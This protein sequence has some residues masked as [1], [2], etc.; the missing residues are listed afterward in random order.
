[1]SLPFHLALLGLCLFIPGAAIPSQ[2]SEC[3]QQ[4]Q[5]SDYDSNQ[6]L[7]R[8]EYAAAIE[9][10]SGGEINIGF[11]DL[12]FKIQEAFH[13]A[14]SY[15]DLE[16]FI[17]LRDEDS[18]GSICGTIQGA[19]DH[20]MHMQQLAD[21][22]Q[23]TQ[24]LQIYPTPSR[25]PQISIGLDFE[26]SRRLQTLQQCYIA[27]SISDS[28]RDNSVSSL[29]YVRFINQL[30][31]Q[32][33]S[34]SNY[35]N[36]PAPLQANFDEFKGT[37]G[38]IDVTGS[39]PGQ[40]PTGEQ[41]VALASICDT[42]IL[43]L[44]NLLA[45]PATPPPGPAPGPATTSAPVGGSGSTVDCDGTI[46]RSRCNIALSIADLSRDDLLTQVEYVRFINRL[47]QNAYIG[48][49]YLSLPGNLVVNF[50]KFALT[51]GQI[52]VTGSKSGST[53]TGDQNVFIDS[54]CCETDFAVQNPEAPTTQAPVTPTP[55]PIGDIPTAP[56]PA[57]ATLP[58]TF[59][60][61]L[62]RSA[63][64]S[65]D[66]DQNAK[67]D[68][69]EYVRYLNRLTRNDFLGLE[70]GELDS[71][72]QI[73]FNNLI[74]GDGQIV[75]FGTR[76]NQDADAQQEEFI[77]R[78]CLDTA[79]ALNGG[80][81]G[82]PA[83]ATQ[84]P[85]RAPQVPVPTQVPQTLAPTFNFISC[86]TA[87]A[88]S[89][90]NRDDMINEEEYVRFLNRL[91]KN[92]LIGLNFEDLESPLPEN[93]VS[94]AKVDGQINIVGSKPGQT[95]PDE[96][97]DFLEQLCV[98]TA[99]AL[100]RVGETLSPTRAPVTPAIP[101]TPTVPSPTMPNL[102]EGIAEVYNSFIVS[103][104]EGLAAKQLQSGANRDDLDNGYETFAMQSVEK[105]VE[106][107]R[108]LQKLENP[109]SLRR[110]R[111]VSTFVADSDEIYL[112]QDVE[113]PDA[114]AENLD[115]QVAFAKFQVNVDDDED[116][117]AI[118]EIYTDSTQ[119]FIAAGALQLALLERDDRTRLTIVKESFPVSSTFS[120]SQAPIG[121][122]TSA[123]VAKEE[124]GDGGGGGVV[125]IVVGIIVAIVVIGLLAYAY[126]KGWI[127]MPSGDSL[128]TGDKK[129]TKRKKTDDD[130]DDDDEF[131][132][133]ERDDDDGSEDKDKGNTFGLEAK[134]DNAFGDDDGDPFGAKEQATDEKKGFGFG[135]KK[136]KKENKG[137]DDN[138]AFGEPGKTDTFGENDEN[139]DFG[140][141]AFDEP[142]I[143]QDRQEALETGSAGGNETNMFETPESPGGGAGFGGDFFG[144]SEPGWGATEPAAGEGDN[145]F[146]AAGGFGEDDAKSQGSQSGSGSYTSSDDSTYESNAVGEGD[147]EGD[148][149]GSEGSESEDGTK[150]EGSTIVSES[151]R[152]MPA[153]LRRKS[154]N[155][156]AM[157]EA[158]NWDAIANAATEFEGGSPNNSKN[159]REGSVRNPESIA[160]GDEDEDDSYSGSGSQSGSDDGET[161]ATS[162]HTEAREKRAEY[163]AQVEALVR[164]VVPD[165]LGKVDAMM[166]QFEG[167]EAELVSTLQ[168]MQERSATQRARAAVHKSKTKPTRGDGTRPDGFSMQTGLSGGTEGSAAGTAAI[169]AASLPIPADGFEGAD[170][171]QDDSM[172]FGNDAFGDAMDAEGSY[173]DDGG[174]QG[175]RSYYSDED[176]SRSGS[177]SY[178]SDEEGGSQ[179]S[180]SYYS[181][182]EG[183]SQEGGSQGGGSQVGSQDG[184][185]SYYSDEEEGSPKGSSPNS[186]GSKGSRSFDGEA[187]GSY[188]DDGSEGDEGAE[189]DG[190]Q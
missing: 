181:D 182:E 179:G 53:P 65:S 106:D 184:S 24:N 143:T 83:P 134:K 122:T 6:R 151:S 66:F 159:S 49:D 92:S 145:F 29:E 98:D 45:E 58:P 93:F 168:T 119:K 32:A 158:G 148:P 178:Y 86:R 108:R 115:C 133:D 172:G 90:F 105:L 175:S 121:A 68:K 114:S 84:T 150:E 9:E 186:L 41:E 74:G 120:P 103:N 129:K 22:P 85:T 61:A 104:I 167:R 137:D 177:R 189:D 26:T 42:T 135:R 157:I 62:C 35:P 101:D 142:S 8:S 60:P 171:P 147:E 51:G 113:C 123:P 11:L 166:E 72:M 63:M 153:D 40:A 187:S 170:L 111:L 163:Q 52:D 102:P 154:E 39:K 79:I 141:Y 30:S 116:P 109:S 23:P 73:N 162:L 3:I 21:M 54:L 188:T 144:G 97:Q 13:S 59:I 34:S 56:S 75:I 117:G 27:M 64:A 128:N 28:N 110:R 183:G 71:L 107:Q 118:S 131:G 174:S 1:M 94:L 126:K 87:M 132:G 146:S 10:L 161:T 173:T 130:D 100:S 156:D 12:P 16:P 25:S 17:D 82:T 33:Y 149:E 88:S 160:E 47:S 55:A 76:P 89:D 138:N 91:T 70:F 112:L 81:G 36:L 48:V 44:D 50:N 165:E 136:D 176:G 80:E 14:S 15:S 125:G 43:L 2:Q 78:I 155:M 185:R 164:L 38:S 69:E 152:S 124:D 5:W 96:Q 7:S 95:V 46:D 169:A 20:V 139:L 180:R 31:S 77:E 127:S 18:V 19:V 67:L 4:I 57:T 37:N 140:D 99:V 190:W